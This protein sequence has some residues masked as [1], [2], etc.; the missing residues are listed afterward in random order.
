[1]LDKRIKQY[2]SVVE[3]IMLRRISG[4]MREDRISNEYVR[5]S[6]GVASIINKMR[7]INGLR[8]FA[9][10]IRREESKTVRVLIKMN[11]EG[12]RRG[13]L[14]KGYLDSDMIDTIC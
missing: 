8:W 9:H 1:V 5:G 3:I 4:V 2:M 6:I 11:V 12:K 13:R 7:E 10:M 14:K